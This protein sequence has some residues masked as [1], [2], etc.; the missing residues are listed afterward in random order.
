[1]TEE[2]ETGHAVPLIEKL[3][4]WAFKRKTVTLRLDPAEILILY[5][6]AGGESLHA[7]LY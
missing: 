2:E 3:L 7:T 1:M 6:R 4:Y 5:L